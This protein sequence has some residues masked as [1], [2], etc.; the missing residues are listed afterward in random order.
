[1]E[2]V[3]FTGFPKTGK[4]LKKEFNSRRGIEK[5]IRSSCTK[6]PQ[7]RKALIATKKTLDS[8]NEAIVA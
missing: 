2:T 3:V 7:D 1:M 6:H 5:P 4:I 8:D